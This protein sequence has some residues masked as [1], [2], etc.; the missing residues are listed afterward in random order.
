MRWNRK[1]FLL[2]GVALLLSAC[3]GTKPGLLSP[4]DSTEKAGI[5]LAFIKSI[6]TG[7]DGFKGIGRAAI[8][9]AG[10]RQIMGTAWM[11]AGEDKLRV[12][13]LDPTGRPVVTFS[14]DGRWLYLLSHQPQRFYKKRV[15]GN[16]LKNLLKIPIK[17]GD[18]T[19]LL[20]GRVPLR[21]YRSVSVEQ[22]PGGKSSS[23]SGGYGSHAAD[24][25]LVFKGL[26]GNVIQKVTVN[27][28]LK[29]VHQIEFFETG[30]ALAYRVLLNKMRGAG[31]YRIPSELLFT[32]DGSSSLTINTRKYWT[33]VPV[34]LSR[35]VL[36]LPAETKP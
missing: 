18:M 31:K 25:V 5:L 24:T 14:S 8:K 26:F 33:D 4:R 19:A 23:E 16:S 35:F 10:A 6:N 12:E 15:A 32:D 28:E 30:G 7:L 9:T 2:I 36:T 21:E 20:A 1:A 27:L 22:A 34:E 11:A 13:V 29:K 17:P 3:A